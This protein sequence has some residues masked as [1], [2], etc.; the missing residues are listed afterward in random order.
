MVGTNAGVDP[1]GERADFFATEVLKK[2]DSLSL[3]VADIAGTMDGLTRFVKHQEDLFGH[4]KSIAH[5]MAGTIGLIDAA[6]RETREVTTQAGQQSS[7]SLRTIDEALSGVN[8]LVGAV[9]RIEEQLEGLE[10]ALGEVGNMSRNIQKIARQT[11]LLAL[12]ATIEA[13]RAGDAGKGFAVVATEVKTLAR[14][15]A[16]VTAGIDTT[17]HKL[18]GSVTD[19]ISSSTDTLKMADSVGSGV[20]VINNA[21]SV[22]GHA[23][24]TVEG[25]VG[26][27]SQA[28]STSLTQ[29][30]NV[31]GEIDKFFEG[32]AMTSDS[33]RKAD[34]RITSLLGS[35]EELMGFIAD[36]G[37]K[38]ADTPFI[39]AAKDTAAKIS[40]A[41]EAAIADGRISLA[42]L[43]DESYQPIAGTNPQQHSTRYTA[44][45]DQ[46]LPQFQEPNLTLDSRVAFC[47]SIDRNGYIGT[48]NNKVSQ[49]QGS[50]PV[51][52]NANCRNRRIFNDRTGLNAGHNT[53]PFLLQT[54]RRD[55]GGGQFVMMKDVSAPIIVQ[56]RHWGGLRLGYRI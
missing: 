7:E 29:C 33:L 47:V 42:D 50:D 17:V 44:F 52:N 12:N 28:A 37:F 36:S 45:T 15:T 10:G 34:E 40:Q 2:I 13:A 31:I 51:W 18:S 14:Q 26:D 48:H 53:K 3:E 6:G 11:N 38:T 56:G 24:G 1:T 20:G 54:Y 35:S 32:I 41:F 30:Q 4:L 43:F 49:P 21:V 5:D 23:I 19:L 9:Q 8:R 39:E 25:K 55:M 16:D 27:I 46:A 22:F